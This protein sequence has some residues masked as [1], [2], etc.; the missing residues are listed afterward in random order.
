[1]QTP[2]A[3]IACPTLAA[4]RADPWI[5]STFVSFEALFVL[6][7]TAGRYKAD[8]RFQWIAEWIS[9]DL[10]ALFL[11]LS[12]AAAGMVV[13][14][15]Q[16]RFP[17]GLPAFLLLTSLLFG[18]AFLS[19]LWTPGAQ[20][21]A[22]KSLHIAVLTTWSI[23][24]CGVVI[25]SDRCRLR[26]FLLLIVLF[27]IW[28]SVESLICYR[29]GPGGSISAL[30][31][32]YLGLGRV[33]GLAA[34][35]VFAHGLFIA[36]T[37]TVRALCF[38]LF[39]FFFLVLL[40]LGGRMPLMATAAGAL[41]PAGLVMFSMVQKTPRRG[42]WLY[43][44]LL[45]GA[46]LGAAHLFGLGE[47]APQTLRRIMVLFD[48]QAGTSAMSRMDG[49][50]AAPESIQSR[51]VFGHGIGSWPILYLKMD[52]RSYPHNLILETLVEL[53]LCGLL[54]LGALILCALRRLGTITRISRD[55]LRIMVL[56]LFV[57]VL[58]NAM[59]SGDIPD[60][61]LMFGVLGLMFFPKEQAA[62][63]AKP[64]AAIS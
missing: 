37:T 21:A 43:L 55:P 58:C 31:G 12:V 32:N 44:A 27:A 60:N 3:R 5:V 16:Y 62:F 8:P 40:I 13:L 24:G 64:Q 35:V 50:H 49:F 11:L 25:A 22:T 61:R 51:P 28:L 33:I 10:T 4:P 39:G 18:Y 7:L 9:I 52:V 15:R 14:G 20:Y 54:L 56:M 2:S 48:P 23:V 46:G 63:R 36:R 17:A 6:F 47:S 29:Q 34:I 41:V 30:G 42:M 57:N 59:V 26:R 45:L 19:R 53:G 38:A 1:M